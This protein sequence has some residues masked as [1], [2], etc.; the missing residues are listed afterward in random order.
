MCV[1]AAGG[2]WGSFGFENTDRCSAMLASSELSN[3]QVIG[4]FCSLKTDGH[5]D[6]YI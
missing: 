5:Q 1:I 3:T 6:L 2:G 4:A